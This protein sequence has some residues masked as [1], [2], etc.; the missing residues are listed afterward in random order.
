LY[1]SDFSSEVGSRVLKAK[2]SCL[3]PSIVRSTKAH[4]VV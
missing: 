1:F 2:I 4:V 3:I